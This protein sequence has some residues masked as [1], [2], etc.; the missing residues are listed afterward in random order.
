MSAAAPVAAGHGLEVRLYSPGG[1]E[2]QAFAESLRQ[3]PPPPPDQGE[4]EY[5]RH[6]VD[7]GRAVQV[8]ADY[9]VHTEALDDLLGR[10]RER[11]AAQPELSFAEFRE[12]SGLTRKLGIPMLEYLD[13]AGW[14]TRTGDVRVAGPRFDET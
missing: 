12:L 2:W 13:Q 3:A 5:L 11:F 9:L 8:A 10:L 14:T 1:P 7:H 6:L 4:E